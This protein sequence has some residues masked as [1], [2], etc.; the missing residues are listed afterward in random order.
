MT[1]VVHTTVV[2]LARTAWRALLVAM[3]CIPAAVAQEVVSDPPSRVA[4][5]SHTDGEVVVAPAGTEEWAEAVLNRPLTNG[6]RLWTESGARAELQVGSAAVYLDE[7]SSFSFVELDDDVM[8]MSLTGGAAT[9]RIRR[10]GENEVIQIETPNVAISLTEPGEYHIE[11]DTQADRTIVKTRHGEAEVFAN[12]QTH[13]VRAD[14]RGTFS[15]LDNL[16]AQTEPLHAR[17]SFENWAND[18]ERRAYESESAQYVSRDVVGYEDLDAHGDWLH[19]AEYGYVW[20]PRYV[21]RH[22][23]PYRDGRWVWVSPWGWTWVDHARWGFAPFHYGRWAHVRNRWCWVPGPRHLRPVYAPAL[24][25]WI[26][27]PGLNVSVSFGSGIGWFPLGPREV[28]VPGYWHSPRY[29]R[30][31][32]VSNTII[33]NNTYIT[34]VYAGR[35]RGID[36]RYGRHPHAIT[37]VERG[38]FLG[39][40]PVRGR[41]LRVSEADLRQWQHRHRPPAL[42]PDRASVLA[43]SVRRGPPAARVTRTD[44][45]D[46]SNRVAFETERRHIEANGGRPVGRTHLYRDGPKGRGD[47]IRGS[48]RSDA[49]RSPPR[50]TNQNRAPAA[51]GLSQDQRLQTAPARESSTDRIR[52]ASPNTLHSRSPREQRQ[53]PRSDRVAEPST[54][55]LRESNRTQR[56]RDQRDVRESNGASR[57]RTW[58]VA[59]RPTEQRR[60]VPSR[61]P[62]ARTPAWRAPPA[63]HDSSSNR[64]SSSEPRSYAPPRPASPPA[65]IE[66]RRPRVERQTPPQ[67]DVQQPSRVQSSDPPQ[68]RPQSSPRQS[69]GARSHRQSDGRGRS[70][71]QKR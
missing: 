6:D 42:T 26:G 35:H 28:Y 37:A 63:R 11:V 50:V 29:I 71:Q 13:L 20:R 59:P 67:R 9:L 70:S 68:A 24:V 45:R 2:P 60:V 25:G 7:R 17:T 39:G 61:E 23:V 53:I 69:S 57:E 30:H 48:A 56:F 19:E 44:N 32:N 58:N 54:H 38:H 18:R 16:S 10:R 46:L 4:R 64:P 43:G 33:V 49:L 5:L 1:A 8:Q 22:W 27:R 41:I 14:E 65:R 12:N 3:F 15:G 36:Y 34:N 21:S 47:F 62:D 40:R 51:N 66:S 31:V 52:S 55:A